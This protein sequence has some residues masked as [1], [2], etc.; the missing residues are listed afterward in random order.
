MIVTMYVLG[1]GVLGFGIIQRRVRFK[2]SAAGGGASASGTVRRPAG[3][4]AGRSGKAR[5]AACGVLPAFGALGD[6]G[7]RWGLMSGHP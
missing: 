1:G 7:A 2:A 5:R 6:V 3:E 4:A